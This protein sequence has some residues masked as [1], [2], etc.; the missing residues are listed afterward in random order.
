MLERMK[1]RRKKHYHS[2]AADKPLNAALYFRNRMSYSVILAKILPQKYVSDFLDGNL[3]MNTDDFFTE[4]ESSDVLRS[5][6]Y[7][8]AD[9]ARQFKQI[10]IKSS[11]GEWVPIKGARSP[12]IHRYREKDVRHILCMY[13]F[14]DRPDFCFDHR[15]IGFGDTAILITDLKEFLKRVKAAAA[16]VGKPLFH[17]PVEYVDKQLHDGQMGPFRKFSEY[18]YQSEFRLVM[19]G[20]E[21]FGR[22][23]CRERERL[24]S[25]TAGL[26]TRD[27]GDR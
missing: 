10:S 6:I 19:V 20:K 3:H 27:D 25:D 2:I 7:E 5:D 23:S 22:A 13:M 16:A 15:N 4:I 12:L 11:S 1:P 8:G 26:S 9:E 14:T 24:V 18:E 17:G 21:K